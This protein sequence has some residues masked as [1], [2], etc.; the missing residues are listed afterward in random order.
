MSR[1]SFA[2]SNS[3]TGNSFSSDELFKLIGKDHVS[4]HSGIPGFGIRTHRSGRQS[5]I[6]FTRIKGKVTRVSLGSVRIVTEHQARTAAM[7][8]VYEAKTGSDPL[9]PKRTK[10]AMPTFPAFVAAD[11]LWGMRTWQPSTIRTY[12]S[13]RDNHLLPAFGH[14]YVDQITQGMVYDWFCKLSQTTRGA[15]NRALE[16]L[17]AAFERAIQWG[18]KLPQ[19]NPCKGITRNRQKAYTRVLRDDELI[20]IGA[21]LDALHRVYPLQTTALRLLMLTGCRHGEILNLRWEQIAGSRLNLT[22]SK[23]GPR[24]VQL[25]DATAAAL[26][27]VPRHPTSPWLFPQAKD[28]T[29]PIP[30]VGEFWHKVVL[31]RAKVKPLRIHDLRHN[32]ASHAAILKENTIT[33]AQLLGHSGTDN[34]HRYM[35]LADKPIRD[36]ADLVCGIIANALEGVG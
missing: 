6:V 34:T 10:R 7:T 21:A 1:T 35:H 15:A 16:I 4:W 11:E 14:L 22:K 33:I 19:G 31:K 3:F 8:I 32:Y 18:L 25:G 24:G 23:T 30:S 36:A 27:L 17:R 2:K 26:R 5:W 13:Y 12:C 29:K 28:P 20:R 9:A